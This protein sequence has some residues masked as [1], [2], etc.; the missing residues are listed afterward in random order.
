MELHF[1]Y[2]TTQCATEFQVQYRVLNTT[3]WWTL[4]CSSPSSSCVFNADKTYER[5]KDYYPCETTTFEWRASAKT[6]NGWSG[7][8]SIKTFKAYCIEQA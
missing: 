4:T 8:T 7:Y 5:V 1:C 3:N 6:G 2:G